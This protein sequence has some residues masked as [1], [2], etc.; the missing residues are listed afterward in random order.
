MEVPMMVRFL[1]KALGKKYT[2]FDPM[3][4]CRGRPP[5]PQPR[6][7]PL[8]VSVLKLPY[9]GLNQVLR[10]CN[11]SEFS[12]DV[13]RMEQKKTRYCDIRQQR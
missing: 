6:M 2:G 11:C 12:C 9:T 3:P 7:L 10:A 1:P 8:P 4:F 13:N 5:C